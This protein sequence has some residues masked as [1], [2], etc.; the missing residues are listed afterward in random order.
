[1]HLVIDGR[2]LMEKQATGVA[3]YTR[4][5]IDNLPIHDATLLLNAMRRTIMRKE[6]LPI[7]QIPTVYTR[8]PNKF[9]S[10]AQLVGLPAFDLIHRHVS[11]DLYWLPNFDFFASRRPYVLTAHDLSFELY[12]DFFSAKMRFHK[13]FGPR[14]LAQMAA[15]II[16]VSENTKTDLVKFY[17][18]R[19]SQVY[20]IYPGVSEQFFILEPPDR[21][22][23]IK[24][25]YSL[26]E[27]FILY[28]GTVE[29]RKNI[30]GIIEAFELFRRRA[31]P[32]ASDVHLV[33]AGRLGWLYKKILKQ[34]R[35]SPFHESI[36]YVNYVQPEDKPGLYQLASV[37]VYPSFYEG[38]GFPPLE[39]AASRIPVIASYAGSLAEVL[40]QSAIL[41]D[42]YN[43][44]Q[45]SAMIASV[46]VSPPSDEALQT[47]AQDVKLKYSWEKAGQQTAA[48]FTSI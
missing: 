17:G 6:N 10:L 41:V 13:A 30:S 46:L 20:V 33:I 3:E 21:L 19:A 47:I 38:F 5:I 12:P 15:K 35:S 1:M 7:R 23:Q 43:I 4:N 14:R 18:V 31:G 16:A 40:G 25:K 2:C 48:V 9:L 37:F 32:K 34:L 29:P 11:P 22:K 44:N 39:A 27:K 8:W 45:I 24:G 36:K 28:L 26:P 42:P